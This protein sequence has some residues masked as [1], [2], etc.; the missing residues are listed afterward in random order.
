MGGGG[1]GGAQQGMK[2]VLAQCCA[3]VDTAIHHAMLHSNLSLDIKLSLW[4]VSN[5]VLSKNMVPGS[6]ARSDSSPL[7]C[8]IEC[9]AT[10]DP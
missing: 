4:N 3:V 10:T 6:S 5:T 1:E 2:S 8:L 9:D 7:C